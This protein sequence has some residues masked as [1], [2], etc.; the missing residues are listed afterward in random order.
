MY[1]NR[2]IR[3]YVGGKAFCEVVPQKNGQEAPE[4]SYNAANK[5]CI[6]ISPSEAGDILHTLDTRFLSSLTIRMERRTWIKAGSLL[7]V[8]NFAEET[9]KKR[10]INYKIRFFYFVS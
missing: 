2:K 3:K 8:E 10:F 9:G 5:K 4:N 6:M 1:P 7:E